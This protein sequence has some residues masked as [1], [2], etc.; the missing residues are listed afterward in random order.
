MKLYVG[1]TCS[2]KTD[3]TREHP[4][5]NIDEA[6]KYLQ[7]NNINETAEVIILEVRYF[8][9]DVIRFSIEDKPEV[10]RAE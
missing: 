9:S 8:F 6:R 2:E 4:F 7:D 1:K 10:Y 3:G 5:K